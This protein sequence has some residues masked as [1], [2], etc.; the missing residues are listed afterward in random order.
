MANELGVIF[1]IF[2]SISGIFFYKWLT[3]YFKRKNMI[4]IKCHVKEIRNITTYYK[5]Y[6]KYYYV[7]TINNIEYTIYDN[8]KYNYLWKKHINDE[9]DMYI[10]INKQNN[11]ISPWQTYLSKLYLKIIITSLIIPFIIQLFL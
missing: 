3:I 9:L 11:I 10:D 4:L 8:L 7:Y 1:M 2:Y 5:D 6:H